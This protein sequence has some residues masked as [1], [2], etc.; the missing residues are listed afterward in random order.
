MSKREQ[1]S[2]LYG[3]DAAKEL[4][5][6]DGKITELLAEYQRTFVPEG[7]ERLTNAVEDVRRHVLHVV[8]DKNQ[9]AIAKVNNEVAAMAAWKRNGMWEGRPV[10]ELTHVVTLPSFRGNRLSSQLTERCMQE[11]LAIEPEALF[12]VFTKTPELKGKYEKL[13]QLG[14]CEN[15]GIEGMVEIEESNGAP[16]TSPEGMAA[17]KKNCSEFGV[18]LLDPKKMAKGETRQ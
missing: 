1:P 12:Y 7:G 9:T 4:A 3:E 15:I 5:A 18:Y 14:A 8:N 10:I 11:A 2:I 17:M 6:N 16:P 13:V